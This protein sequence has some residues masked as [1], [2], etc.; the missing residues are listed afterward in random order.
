MAAALLPDDLAEELEG[1]IDNFRKA[2]LSV[3]DF[4]LHFGH[5]KKGTSVRGRSQGGRRRSLGVSTRVPWL[6][7]LFEE[8]QVE[9]GV[10]GLVGHGVRLLPGSVCGQRLDQ[11]L[12]QV[13]VPRGVG[14]LF[15]LHLS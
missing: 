8:V 4:C 9:F 13:S 6:C 1:L 3:F 10:G 15:W 2:S 7:E 14:G 5:F 12:H 11:S